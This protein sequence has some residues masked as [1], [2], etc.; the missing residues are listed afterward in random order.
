MVGGH[1]SYGK[2]GGSHRAAECAHSISRS[3]SF[4]PIDPLEIDVGSSPTT[5]S[6]EDDLEGL[7]DIAGGQSFPPPLHRRFIGVD[8][9]RPCY[10]NGAHKARFTDRSS[11]FGYPW[12]GGHVPLALPVSRQD[13][14]T[15]D[16]AFAP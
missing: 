16:M 8:P 3:Y 1:L 15:R 13:K 14:D 2:S 7:K 11:S 5:V 12:A 6:K 9:S 4:G 10:M